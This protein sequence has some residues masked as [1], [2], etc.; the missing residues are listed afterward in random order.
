MKY[1]SSQLTRLATSG[2]LRTVPRRPMAYRRLNED[3]W[4]ALAGVFLLCLML[5]I[6]LGVRGLP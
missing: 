4:L 6:V 1:T 5:M 2:G 3:R